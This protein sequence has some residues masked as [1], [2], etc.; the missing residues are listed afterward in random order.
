M[1]TGARA[2]EKGFQIIDQ[3]PIEEM[4][5]GLPSLVG[6]GWMVKVGRHDADETAACVPILA[7]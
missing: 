6:P 4:V 7:H 1:L 5:L 3:D 2:L